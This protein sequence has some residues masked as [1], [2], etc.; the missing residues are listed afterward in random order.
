[1]PHT[2]TTLRHPVEKLLEAEHFLARMI[3][4]NGLVFQFE[5]NA[6]LSASR[7]VS[8]V[9]QKSFSDVPGFTFW[10]AEQ[11]AHMKA[12]P[13]MR[14]FLELRNISQKQG[15]IS[16]VGGS[17]PDGR[18]TYRF[19]GRPHAVP[20]ELKGRDVIACCAAHLTKLGTLLAECV[21][22]FPFHSCP[23]RAFTEEGMVALGYDWR[24]VEAALGLP[25]GYTDVVDFP[26]AEKLRIL[27]REIEPL[28]VK[29]IQRIAEGDIRANGMRLQFPKT[30][31]TDLVD[32]IAA[33]MISHGENIEQP[34]NVFISAIA[35]RINGTGLL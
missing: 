10:Y 30:S 4:S 6:F 18:W 11:Q 22:D 14:F 29:S 17:L 19:V 16:F 24:D 13:A 25:T 2:F 9:L 21:Q 35:K 20:T 28:D 12:D 27:R 8:F 33:M 32:D 15:P 3:N 34:R 7:S 31:G 5:I 26:A 1:M 23:S